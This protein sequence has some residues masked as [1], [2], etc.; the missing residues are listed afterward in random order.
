VTATF[1]DLVLASSEHPDAAFALWENDC[2]AQTTTAIIAAFT[3]Q[4][5]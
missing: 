5:K 1:G 2:T 3:A 4:W